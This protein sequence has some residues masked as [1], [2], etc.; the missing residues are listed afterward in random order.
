M[1]HSTQLKG[2]IA[3]VTVHSASSC[4]AELCSECC[5]VFSWCCILS[6]N[7]NRSFVGDRK[8]NELMR[9]LLCRHFNGSRTHTFLVIDRSGSMRSRVITPD[10]SDIREHEAFRHGR[11]DNVLGVVYEAAHKYVLERASKS[12]EELFTFIPFSSDAEIKFFAKGAT[13]GSVAG[14]LDEFMECPPERGTNFYKALQKTKLAVTE[15]RQPH[16]S[17]GLRTACPG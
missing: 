3:L 17:A 1:Q 13:D 11:L 7:P 12:H 8:I 4:Y 2:V 16:T 14:L 10:S 9:A 15:V 6:I 5:L